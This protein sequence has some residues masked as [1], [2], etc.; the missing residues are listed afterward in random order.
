MSYTY[1]TWLAA[2]A[3]AI[4][5]D[6]ADPNFTTIIPSCIDYAEQ[7]IY[8]EL[9][10][11][12]TVVRDSSATLTIGTRN[13]TL[14]T[15][16]GRFVVTNG[17]NVITPAGTTTPD[18]GTRVQLVPVSR[19]FLDM[20]WPSVV[21]AATPS[22][23]AMITDQQ[24]IVGPAPDAAYT[25][26]VIGTIRPNPLSASNTMTYLT[27]YLPD[28][29]F[30]ATMVFLTGYQ[31]NFGAQADNPQMAVS[32]SSTYDKL[33]SSANIEEQRKRY[34]SGAWGSLSPTPIATPSR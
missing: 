3:D 18:S 8:R 26:E 19:D 12:D 17:I 25:V 28:L 7:R 22:M 10:L 13:F 14:P 11:L 4:V 27:Q 6:Q 20:A 5:I 32:W 34:A 24:I 31:Q 29:W 15:S 30:A 9:D 21:G 16:L 2:V 33:I 23:Y 1:A